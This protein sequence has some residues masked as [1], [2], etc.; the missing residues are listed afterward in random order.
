MTEQPTGQALATLANIDDLTEGRDR[1]IAL[2]LDTYDTLHTNAAAAGAASIGGNIGFT[3]P[4]TGRSRDAYLTAA[5]LSTATHRSFDRATGRSSELGAREHYARTITQEVDRRCWSHLMKHLGF[6][7]L[8]D[9]Q[10]REEFEAGL[11]D[12]PPAFT[13][14]NCGATFGNLWGNRREMYLRGIA[15]VF[16]AMDRRFRSHDAFAVGN[17]LVIDNAFRVGWGGWQ[18]YDRRDTLRDVERIFRELDELPPLDHGAGEAIHNQIESD[19][20][21]ARRA[22]SW[23]ALIEGPYFR[24]RAFKNGNLHLWFTRKD[25]LKQVNA[26]L[27][28]YYNPLEGDK[29]EGPSYEAGPLYHTAPAKYFGA[30]NSSADVTARVMELAEIAEGHTVLEPSA[31]TGMLAKAAKARGATVVCIE[32]QPGLAHELRTLH[33]FPDTREDDFLRVD[34]ARFPA[35]DRIVMNP[36]FDRGRDCDHVRHAYQFLKPGGRLVAIMSARAEFGTD[37]RHKA[38]HELIATTTGKWGNARHYWHDLPEK[39]F[40]HAGTNVNTVML[41]FNKPR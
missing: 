23:P 35:F 32:V 34:P 39:S 25:L 20:D 2:W 16:M 11:R 18:S 31:G 41:C 22:D 15:N 6:D 33:G 37:A 7:A 27:L 8:L 24:V 5:L 28:E 13:A 38:L 30:F 17:R 21:A 10:A 26:L 1:A 3:A 19:N 14:D 9:R 40:A 4:D 36:P 29:G 12:N